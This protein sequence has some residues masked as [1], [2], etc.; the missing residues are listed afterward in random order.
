MGKVVPTEPRDA[1]LSRVSA[2]NVGIHQE[3]PCLQ[4]QPFVRFRHVRAGSSLESLPTMKAAFKKDGLVTAGNASGLNDGAGAVVLADA[5]R[6]AVLG[7]NPLA[8]LVAYLMRGRAAVYG[9][10][11]G[12]CH[13]ARIAARRPAA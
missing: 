3:P 9:H 8:R 6:A 7:L 11:S 5:R 12:A 13:A 10:R 1:Y 4:C 2:K